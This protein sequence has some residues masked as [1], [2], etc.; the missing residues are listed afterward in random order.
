MSAMSWSATS[1]D[2]AP[3][4]RTSRKSVRT[5]RSHASRPRWLQICRSHGSGTSTGVLWREGHLRHLLRLGW[6]FEKGILLKSEQPGGHVGRK[7]TARRVV[8][9]NSLVVAHA[10]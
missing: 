4:T 1:S 7:S 5:Y 2:R 3:A 8:L 9:L 10:L 6:G